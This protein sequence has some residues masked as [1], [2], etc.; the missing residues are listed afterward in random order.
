MSS[1][2]VFCLAFDPT[3]TLLVSGGQDH[4]AIVWNV[5][6]KQIVFKTEGHQDSVTQVAFSPDGAYLAT[7]D[8]AGGIRVWLKPTEISSSSTTQWAL[9]MSETV[10]DLL[11]LRWWQ[12]VPSAGQK[13]EVTSI[14]TS[15]RPAVLTAGDEDGLVAVWSVVP[16][17][18]RTSQVTAPK[19]KY[20]AGS[21]FSA[22]AGLFYLPFIQSDRPKLVVLYRDT[23][24]R[25]WDLKTEE[26]LTS[27]RLVTTNQTDQS[28]EEAE[29]IENKDEGSVFCLAQ[30]HPGTESVQPQSDLVVVGGMNC[31]WLAVIKADKQ[32]ASFSSKCLPPIE[33]ED[34][35]SVETVDFSWTHSF[36]AFG[37]VSGV[38]GIVDTTPMRV[39]QKWTYSGFTDEENEGAGI[40]ALLWSQTAPILFTSTSDGAV[41]SWPG[42]S[43]SLELGGSSGIASGPSPLHVWLGHQAM[44]LD[45]AITTGS[46]NT[47][48]STI[49]LPEQA[50][51]RQLP[52]EKLIA[53]ASDD[54]TV[55]IYSPINKNDCTC[56]QVVL[57]EYRR[58]RLGITGRSSRPV[59]STETRQGLYAFLKHVD[60][61]RPK[62]DEERVV[63]PTQAY[64]ETARFGGLNVLPP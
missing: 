15:P 22:T 28:E 17:N 21:G 2:S 33:L 62:Y 1:E 23:V 56:D 45:L 49:K 14:C 16:P 63:T 8:M 7:G 47:T 29:Q 39:R 61:F 25:L 38:I 50:R 31:L 34:C 24:L 4:V 13:K 54:A 19:V 36:F 30:P 58:R 20:L 32:T 44:I 10:G 52:S 53:S 64:A 12:P 40:T 51:A 46:D 37:T 48:A 6:T 55:R 59:S 41:V 27:V 5:E 60:Q 18:P 9:L 26:V 42:L 57:P 3:G 35:G 43:G 11:W